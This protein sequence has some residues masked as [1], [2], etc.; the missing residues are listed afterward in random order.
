MMHHLFNLFEAIETAKPLFDLST[1]DLVCS[2]RALAA[3]LHFVHGNPTEFGFSTRLLNRTLFIDYFPPAR[4]PREEWD[5]RVYGRAFT[6]IASVPEA[7]IPKDA[8]HVRWVQ[9]PLGD[10]T[11]AVMIEA[12]A[13]AP[14]E[15]ET[16]EPVEAAELNVPKFV[17]GVQLFKA[18]RE[19]AS[20]LLVDFVCTSH[21]WGPGYK[22]PGWYF[23]GAETVISGFYRRDDSWAK[24]YMVNSAYTLQR[25]KVERLHL[26][27]PRWKMG[28]S[29]PKVVTLLRRLKECTAQSK[30]KAVVGFTKGD[31]ET[32][33]MK[34]YEPEFDKEVLAD[35][36]VPVRYW[37]E[38]KFL[39]MELERWFWWTTGG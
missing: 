37:V 32:L 5:D 38:E 2:A 34:I 33:R 7:G 15:N 22:I 14:I 16:I 36:R 11:C 3:L 28:L 23:G 17:Q 12:D 35:R 30:H 9:Y 31:M 20:D 29:V 13:W 39:T 26:T 6:A 18:G 27:A 21:N 19:I 1:I 24:N 4:P 10:L 8:R 25:L